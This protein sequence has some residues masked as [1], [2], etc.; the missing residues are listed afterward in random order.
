[1]LQSFI[2]SIWS[3]AADRRARKLIRLTDR[4]RL[5][6]RLMTVLAAGAILAL[7]NRFRLAFR[8]KST[9]WNY[10]ER[11]YW[12]MQLSSKP[13]HAWNVR[14]RMH[15]VSLQRGIRRSMSTISRGFASPRAQKEEGSISSL[16]AS[17]SGETSSVFPTW[18]L[19][20]KRVLWRDEMAQS[21]RDVLAD[22][23]AAV[24]ELS[25]RKSEVYLQPSKI[26]IGGPEIL[27]WL[28]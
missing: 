14:F 19:D 23:E 11:S 8:T 24:E 27:V 18:F 21:W 26:W 7:S 12:I 20:L 28:R 13:Q 6:D 16:F 25:R 5:T 2:E 15:G 17:L 4:C 22:L 10:V 1:M 3:S 9:H